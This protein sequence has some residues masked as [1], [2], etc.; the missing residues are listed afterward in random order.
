LNFFPVGNA[1][2]NNA[3][4]VGAIDAIFLEPREVFLL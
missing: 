4:F 1:T 3:I 2:K